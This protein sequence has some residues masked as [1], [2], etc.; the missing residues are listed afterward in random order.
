MR[1]SANAW[2]DPDSPLPAIRQFRV[3]EPATESVRGITR[4]S[5][6]VGRIQIHRTARRIRQHAVVRYA[7]R[8]LVED[9][10]RAQSDSQFVVE[11]SGRELQVDQP[12]GV[13][14]D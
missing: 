9:I 10:V 12:V 13:D 5:E 8:V 3:Q 4:E 11:Q 14:L 7:V 1:S 2:P 6:R